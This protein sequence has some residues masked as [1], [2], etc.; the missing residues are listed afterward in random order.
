MKDLIENFPGQLREAIRIGEEATLSSAKRKISNVFV[1]GLGGS[2]IGGT[3]VSELVA[4]EATVSI[5]VS[6]GYFIPKYINENTLVIISSYSGNTEETL[7]CLNLALKR[8]AKIVCITSGGKVAEIA[9]KKKL[10]VILIPGG[11]PPRACLGYSLTQL[12][13]IL[14]FHKIITN[15]FKAQLKSSIELIEAE[16]QCIISEANEVADKIFGKTP[17]IYATT[18]FE[19]IAVRFRQQINE[20]AKMLCGHHVIP[21]MNHNELVG[22][23][24]GSERI[25]VIIFRDKDEFERNN[26]RIE[27]NKEVMRKYTPNITEIWSKGKSQIEK[28]IYFIHLGDWISLFLAEKRGV[29]AVEV[30]VIDML[31]GEL[32]KI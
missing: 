32:S 19:G 29:D 7:N 23:A 25:S 11:N 21:E 27:I 13:F 24:N 28:A 2:G 17:M 6:K 18:Y 10:D 8:K 9:K 22:W 26:A 31:K 12:F 20:N 15:K 14:G 30:K 16:K 5:N 4:L 3:I 1:S